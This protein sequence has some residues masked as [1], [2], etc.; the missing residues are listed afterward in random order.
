MKAALR[1]VLLALSL[2]FTTQLQSQTSSTEAVNLAIIGDLNLTLNDDCQSSLLVSQVLSGDFDADGNGVPAAATD[3]RIIVE[4]DDPSNGPIIDGCGT[5]DFRVEASSL[6]SGFTVGWGTVRAEDKTPPVFTATPGAPPGP[7]FCTAIA[8][9]DI[10]TLPAAVSRCY[11]VVAAT[12]EIIDGSLHPALRDRLE[13]GGGFPVATDN[14]ARELEICLTDIVERAAVNP[15]C[16]D[17][18][19]TRT[20]IVTDGGC[21]TESGETNAPGITS[22]AITFTR[23][24]L[25]DIN[26]ANVPATVEISCTELSELGIAF[27]EVPA[28]RLQDLPFI[29]GP[30]DSRIPLGIGQGKSFCNIGLTAED[31]PRITTCPEAYKVVRT[32]TLID[33]CNPS[34]IETF[35]QTIKIGDFAA[36]VFTPPT[37]DLDFDGL[38]DAGPLQFPTNAGNLCGAYLR[39]DLPG[40]MLTD[41]CS[42]DFRLTASIFPGGDIGA[43]PLGA[44]AIDLQNNQAEISGLVPV[45][46][47]LLRYTYTDACGNT[48]FTDVDITIVDGTEPVAVCEDRL[49]V[50]LSAGTTQDGS[51]DLGLAVLTPAMIDLNSYD[52]CSDVRLAI[53]RVEQLPDGGYRLLP[54][55][56]YGPRIDFTCADLG[57]ALVGLEVTDAEGN[58]NFCWME[59]LVE[60]KLAPVCTPPAP[61]R[62]SCT[63]FADLGLPTDITTA[64]DNE[65]N[66][67]F[68]QAFGQDNCN[69]TIEQSITG[70]VD[71]CG[72][73]QFQRSFTLADLSGNTTTCN[74]TITVQGVFDYTIRFPGDAEAFCLESP[75]LMTVE[76]I[77]G[78]CDLITTDITVDTFQSRVDECFLLRVNH[79]VIN[80]CEYNTLGEPYLIR[81]DADSDDDLSEP[82]FVHLLP[83]NPLTAEDDEAQ[84]DDDA[85]RGNRSRILAAFTLV[86]DGDDNDGSDDQNGADNEDDQA[87]NGIGFAYAQD[88]SRGAFLYHQYISVFDEAPPVISSTATESC[89]SAQNLNCT[90]S[91]QLAFQTSDAC[92]AAEALAVRVALDEDFN[93]AT[94]FLRSRFLLATEVSSTPAGNYTISLQNVPVGQHAVRVRAADGCGNFAVRTIPFCV[95]DDKAPTPICIG[96]LTVTLMPDGEGSGTAAVWANDFIASDVEDCS[97]EVTYSIY[98]EQ[99]ASAT[100]FTPEPGN[101]GIILNCNSAATLPVRVYAFDPTGQAD[102]CSVFVLVQGAQN[103]CVNDE[104]RNIGGALLSAR[105]EVFANVAIGL[106][107]EAL[108]QQAASDAEGRYLFTDLAAGE[109]Y[110]VHPVL[111][112]YIRH[113]Q[114]VST[115]DLVLITRH[116]LGRVPLTNPYQMLAA[117]VN[118]DNEITV[119]D[120]IAIRRLILGYDRRYANNTAYRFVDA[121]FIFP[122][123]TNPWATTFPEVVNLNNLIAN[124]FDADFIGF[125]VGDVNGDGLDNL[126]TAGGRPRAGTTNIIVEDVYLAAGTTREIPLLPGK[127]ATLA[128]F[129]GTFSLA[130]GVR[131]EAV[132]PGQLSAAHYRSVLGE[133]GALGFSF[134]EAS[135][136]AATQPLVHLRLT[137][138]QAGWLHDLLA[139][140]DQQVVTEGYTT[141]DQR[142]SLG[143]RFV[144]PAETADA[145]YLRNFPN[146]MQ[147]HTTVHF[148]LPQPASSAQLEIRDLRG[149]LIHQRSVATSAGTNQ[150]MIQRQDVP[151]A[152]VYTLT[153]AAGRTL[154]TQRF[155]VQ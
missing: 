147:T 64:T 111:D 139:V 107:A 115:F 155:V 73:G 46:T 128:G 94:G 30:E 86:D 136:L 118:N 49:N 91:V 105:G 57:T 130:D 140:T 84:L 45:G 40:V 75:D 31:S 144:S 1:Y 149:R 7:L 154:L 35:T 65:L 142:V 60:D 13:A 127:A 106:D 28:P 59:V 22:Y 74:Q 77:E 85:I 32:Y 34:Q 153:L 36:P 124:V 8:D 109:D 123:S 70:S 69:T 141:T 87:P 25:G 29:E 146:P 101:T 131:L 63:T 44:Y 134:S 151:L 138:T 135:G 143:I 19:L 3:F 51:S 82:V 58:Q 100:G 42:A 76:A 5:Y 62:I 17:F 83:G 122:I 66:V 126:R 112:D 110:T 98:T 56:A 20:F 88:D 55:A 125:M 81:R 99:E 27:G 145:P 12:G 117:D 113:S 93:E 47:H 21:P 14:C 95:A 50:S 33:W 132:V 96:Q 80:F 4:D 104:S 53:A 78:T 148:Q 26:A 152:G 68:G 129:Q 102:Y 6:I 52:D 24:T 54:D 92:T 10:N 90:G 18:T 121:N 120:L 89:F 103:A 137:T 114:G 39:L 41:A 108:S 97:G 16:S 150:L 15:E 116:I 43:N 9:I 37:Q 71:N 11:R 119:Q 133:R 67:A 48:D 79:L 23:P 38:P 2:V 72:Q 61:V